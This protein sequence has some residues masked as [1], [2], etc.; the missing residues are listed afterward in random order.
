MATSTTPVRPTGTVTEHPGPRRAI[1]LAAA[2]ALLT[3]PFGLAANGASASTAEVRGDTVV[4][5]DSPESETLV[6]W[7]RDGESIVVDEYAP[8]GGSPLPGPGC[9]VERRSAAVASYLCSGPGVGSLRLE[10][11]N[12]DDT[13][14]PIAGGL[15]V[16]HNEKAYDD[17]N[18]PVTVLGGDGK[19]RLTGGPLADRVEGGAGDD[20]LRSL[21]PPPGSSEINLDAPAADVLIG[22]A[23]N[24]SVTGSGTL[25]GGAGN[26][27]LQAPLEVEGAVLDGG[28][29][30]DSL[31]AGGG[32]DTLAGADGTDHL[33]GEAG[34]DQLDGGEGKDELEGSGGDDRLVG[35]PGPDTLGGEGGRDVLDGGAAA[36]ELTGGKEKDS[37]LAGIG[38]DVLF[39]RDGVAEELACGDG[40]DQIRD[41]DRGKDRSVPG[42]ACESVPLP[43]NAFKVV[44]GQSRV[45][46]YASAPR[47]G[48]LQ[49]QIKCIAC[50]RLRV[51]LST[52]QFLKGPRFAIG[53]NCPSGKPV[54]LA[55]RRNVYTGTVRLTGC[56]RASLRRH[57]A[58]ERRGELRLRHFT[59]DFTGSGSRGY[60]NLRGRP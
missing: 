16:F 1:I 23:G 18:F 35:G 49:V 12:A 22:D 21:P 38:D 39:A 2:L 7:A 58:D 48:T 55:A 27:E 14:K 41:W 59:F 19:D 20:T 9:A 33:I 44:A 43:P 45:T 29:G 57:V 28:S 11:G 25:E 17:V 31:Q 30:N 32:P 36:D 56:Q 4:Y 54:T 53:A 3:V 37:F 5:T 60:V 51:A 42:A 50:G 15:A 34:N 26:D 8:G 47:R 40:R 13:G 10:L 24:D 6:S 52:W 46:G